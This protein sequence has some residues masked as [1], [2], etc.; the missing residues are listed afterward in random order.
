MD[1]ILN[2]IESYNKIKDELDNIDNE[3][4]NSDFITDS[5]LPPVAHNFYTNAAIFV[6][7]VSG[8]AARLEPDII[9]AEFACD[10]D[11]KRIDRHVAKPLS[12]FLKQ[13]ITETTLQNGDDKWSRF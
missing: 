10:P 13:Y 11:M 5:D 1:N 2:I 6:V 9:K 12:S 8:E 3:I 4:R 7:N